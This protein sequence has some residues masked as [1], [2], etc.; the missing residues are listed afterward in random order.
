MGA[1]F[2]ARTPRRVLEAVGAWVRRPWSGIRSHFQPIQSLSRDVE[3]KG[4]ALGDRLLT[5]SV[6]FSP[7]VQTQ[8]KYLDTQS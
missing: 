6:S 7:L 5:P 1:M 8:N 2:A 3:G 4:Q